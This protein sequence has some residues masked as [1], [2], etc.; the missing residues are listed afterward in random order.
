MS[1]DTPRLQ[2]QGLEQKWAWRWTHDLRAMRVFR[3]AFG[4]T[5]AMGVSFAGNWPLFFIT[6]V[7]VAFM[8]ALPLPPPTLRQG[9][10]NLLYIFIAFAIGLLFTLLLLPYPLV[11]VPALGLILFHVYYL[12][13]RGGPPFL[14]I[15][16]IV[17]V[18]LLPMLGLTH[19]VIA[20]GFAAA[21]VHSG[22]F[23]IV[24]VWL[25]HGVVPDPPDSHP[26]MP[27]RASLSDYSPV[28]AR[29]ALKSTLVTLP[30][31][32]AFIA[33]DWSSQLLVLV[34]AALFSLAPEVSKGRAAA[35]TSMISTLIGGAAALAFYGLIV[36]VPEFH[37][38]LA[39]T[40][41]FA[42]LFAAAIFSGRP[43]A[44]YM[45]SAFIALI[46][47]VGGSMGEDPNITD[48]LMARVLLMSL[49][50]LYIVTALRFLDW[51]AD[52]RVAR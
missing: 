13:N 47:L 8:L 32:T 24:L 36:V 26:P 15:M 12:A 5:L 46:V 1:T 7:L 25:A 43:Y 29:T 37:F 44:A 31:A 11:F 49:A 19:D 14:V 51:V 27:A 3:F 18:L 10:A 22:L 9:A 23:A 4:V 38:F 39:L 17:A 6:P 50:A 42:L 48:K 33:Y 34:F 2:V 35:S 52:R 21:F 41:L 20:G 45:P 40:L 28:A 30:L 16:T